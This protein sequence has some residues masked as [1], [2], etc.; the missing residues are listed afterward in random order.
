VTKFA[1]AKRQGDP[2]DA[3]FYIQEGEVKVSVISQRGKEAVVALHDRGDF[4]GEGCLTENDAPRHVP[5]WS[6]ASWCFVWPAEPLLKLFRY[7]A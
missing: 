5:A 3:V 1:N 6:S 7:D 2:A 4:F